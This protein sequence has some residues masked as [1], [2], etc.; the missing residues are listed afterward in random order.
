MQSVTLA[1]D[2]ITIGNGFGADLKTLIFKVGI[3]A[4]AGMFILFIGFKTRAPGPT[5]M[6]AIFAG[7]M[8]GL[9]LSINTTAQVT[10]DTINQYN[11]GGGNSTVLQGDR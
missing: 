10:S 11:N 5:I 9:S 1:A 6:A 8:V 3:P 2:W 4:L 7:I